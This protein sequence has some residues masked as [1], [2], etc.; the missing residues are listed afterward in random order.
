MR[1]FLGQSTALILTTELPQRR[2]NAHQETENLTQSEKTLQPF[3]QLMECS[4][5]MFLH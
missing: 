2:A 5:T 4:V 1:V 3:K